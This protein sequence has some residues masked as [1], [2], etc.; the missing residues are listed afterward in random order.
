[1]R[2]KDKEISSMDEISQ[3]IKKCQVCRLALSQDDVPYIIPVSFG[4]DGKTLYFHSAK[5]GKKI[6]ILSINNNVC[7]EFESGVEVIVDET[8]PCNWSF[9]F[10]TVIG[11]GKVKELSSPEDKIKGL[12][13]IMAQ[14]SE[15]EWNLDTLPLNG[16]RIWAI[17]IT[18]MTGKQSLDHVDQ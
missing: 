18:S 9:S 15:K 11:F 5:D 2:R 10:Q 8:K 13:H 4:Y 6:D 14:Y 17:N 16:L 7:F 12:K 1:M 3:V